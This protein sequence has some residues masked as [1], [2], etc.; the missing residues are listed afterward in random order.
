M[1][2]ENGD[3]IGVHATYDDAADTL[4]TAAT[5]DIARFGEQS[6]ASGVLST[7]GYSLQIIE[8][9]Q[10]ITQGFAI[11]NPECPLDDVEIVGQG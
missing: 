3:L 10:D 6:A 9:D 2:R 11:N 1:W 4:R 7:F 5:A 8:D